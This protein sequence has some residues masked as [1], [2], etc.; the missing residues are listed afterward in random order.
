MKSTLIGRVQ[1]LEARRGEQ[2]DLDRARRI[3]RACDVVEFHP[4]QATDEDK[5]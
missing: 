4:E 1:R 3:V 5:H 2:S